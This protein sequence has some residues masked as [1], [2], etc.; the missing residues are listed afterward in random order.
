MIKCLFRY[1]IIVDVATTSLPS[2]VRFHS[3]FI[4][5]I[6]NTLTQIWTCDATNILV[7]TGYVVYL[8]NSNG[9]PIELLTYKT[10]SI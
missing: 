7:S 6:S 3:L 1:V 4:L 5:Y 9:T 2:P 10:A 8:N